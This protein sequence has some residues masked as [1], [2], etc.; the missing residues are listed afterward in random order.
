MILLSA[1][2]MPSYI[3]PRTEKTILIMRR[4]YT[5]SV[6]LFTTV[7]M[8]VAQPD[9]G[10]S[11]LSYGSQVLQDAE[12]VTI[13][14][15]GIDLG[16]TLSEDAQL[17]AAGRPPRFAKFIAAGYGTANSGT[18]TP[19]KNGDRVWRLRIESIHAEAITLYYDDFFIPEGGRLFIYNDAHSDHLGAFTHDNN[20]AGGPFAT[21][22]LYGEAC[23]IEYFEPAAAAGQGR[24]SI[25]KVGHAYRYVHFEDDEHTERGGDVCEVD[26]NCSEGANWQDEKRGVVRIQVVDGQGAGWCSGSMVNNTAQDCKNFVLTALHCG[27]NSTATHFNQYIFYYN[28]E[29]TGCGTGTSST[30]QSMT[31][32]VKRA[33]SNDGGGNTGS[34][35]L[36]VELNATPPSNYN[37]YYNGW[38]A[39]NTASSSGVGIHHPAGGRK[40]VSTY[41]SA[42]TSTTWG[43]TVS[44]THWRV[45]WA[46]T[47]NGHG[48]TEGGSSGSP[49]F[50]SSGLIV[51][52][53]TGGGSFCNTPTQPDSYGKVSYH[54]TSNSA[55]QQLKTYLDPGN[56][57]AL[58]LNGTYAPCTPA[59]TVDAG[60]S[61]IVAPVGSYCTT[62]IA[63]VVTLKNFGTSTLTSCTINYNVDGGT[64]STFAWTGSLAANATTNVTLNNITVSV[65]NHTFNANT[66]NPNGQAD[67]NAGNNASSSTFTAS[68]GSA[69]VWVVIDTDN[70]GDETT[71]QITNASNQV[72]ASGGPYANATHYEVQVCVTAGQCYNFTINDSQGDGICCAYGF[73]DY[74]VGDAN[75]VAVASGGQFGTSETTNFCV[76][77][78]SAAG[79]DTLWNPFFANATGVT[80]YTLGTGNGYVSGTNNFGDLAKAQAY[81]A[82]PVGSTVA[83]IG[84]WA[85]AKNSETGT[86]NLRLYNRN[87]T[88]TATSGTV[89]NAPGTVL[90]TTSVTFNQIDTSGFVTYKAFP[91]PV[92][93]SAAYAV[94]VSWTGFTADELAIISNMDGDAN[95]NELAWEQWS[96]NAWHSMISAWTTG[97]DGDLD[98]AIFP[99][100]CSPNVGSTF[101]EDVFVQIYP[102][103][104]S[105]LFTLDYGFRND[106]DVALSIIDA[107]GHTVSVSTLSGQVGHRTLDLSHLPSGIYFARM[108][109]DGVNITHRIAVQR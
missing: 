14:T 85:G 46:A 28:Y 106:K 20:P 95:G 64:N 38:N 8:A 2:H 19:L 1:V 57:G 39:N 69:N 4:L 96:D 73:G 87:G 101:T 89:N 59:V 43:G 88:G 17:E 50:N 36:L 68:N 45:V 77:P 70:Y 55:G 56:T 104:S 93:V 27:D 15:Y 97:L 86:V 11:P 31:G 80:M 53:L 103:P 60:I 75:G 34:D 98:L 9:S 24:I 61:A 6:L 44:N 107:L 51:G 18:W 58:T 72:I 23:T 54:W 35:F 99:V 5:L 74:T 66:T 52:T 16:A 90:A 94:G 62:T 47:A 63:P 79:C 13:R 105:G 7:S 41:T 71:W 40:K 49:L 92:S 22:I 102:N 29:R 78:A 3:C 37:V 32:C 33:E 108:M 42:L 91:S 84:F 65:G 12:I 26:I 81:S 82:P 100:L 67:G 30:S 10:G 109:G 76:Q 25:D 48:V 21:Q 83:G